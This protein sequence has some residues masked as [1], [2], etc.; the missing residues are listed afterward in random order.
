MNES[1]FQTA[2]DVR[3]ANRTVEYLE[4]QM[5]VRNIL[6]A[7]GWYE[8]PE[9]EEGEGESIV[10][11]DDLEVSIRG[12]VLDD[13]VVFDPGEDFFRIR[14]DDYPSDRLFILAVRK[15]FDILVKEWFPGI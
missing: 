13:S 6:A 10:H 3:K 11:T 9:P 4:G 7:H 14:R 1:V 8:I 15:T 12:Y 5:R 2:Y